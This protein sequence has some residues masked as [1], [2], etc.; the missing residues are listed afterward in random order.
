M[1]TRS[2]PVRYVS[3]EFHQ[4]YATTNNKSWGLNNETAQEHPTCYNN[5]P[6]MYQQVNNRDPA[7]YIPNNY[8]ANQYVPA[9]YIQQT[10]PMAHTNIPVSST[11]APSTHSYMNQQQ[12]PVNTTAPHNSMM[13]NQPLA[14][15]SMQTSSK[16]GRNDNSGIPETNVQLRPQY[17][18]PTRVFTSNNTPNKR[19]HRINQQAS[20]RNNGNMD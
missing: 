9:Q 14:S 18:Q 5:A 11:P 2:D 13:N 7:L 16:R 19:Q 4:V 6:M 17:L 1:I 8:I 10:L 20:E 15:T 3:G 12:P